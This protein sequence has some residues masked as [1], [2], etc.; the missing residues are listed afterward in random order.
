MA[1]GADSAKK[2]RNTPVSK[3]LEGDVMIAF[4]QNGNWLHPE[5]GYQM[6]LVV[7]G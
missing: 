4:Y 1:E 2:S 7:P 6:R 3:A 5:Q